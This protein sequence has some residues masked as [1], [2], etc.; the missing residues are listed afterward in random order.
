MAQRITKKTLYAQIDYLNQ[1]LG[2]RT[3]AYTRGLD[4]KV[5][6]NVGTYVLDCAYGGY[7]LGQICS[8]GGGQRDIT[9]RGS[10][11][12][13]YYAIRAFMAG[14]EAAREVAV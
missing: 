8:K 7:R 4:G 12:E 9:A 10:A 2:H 5:Y 13:T 3:K 14:V 11:S 1:M 6:A